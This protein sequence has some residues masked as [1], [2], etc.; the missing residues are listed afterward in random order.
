MFFKT[1]STGSTS[2][3]FWGSARYSDRL[4]DF[5]VTIPRFYKDVYVNSFFPCTARLSNS[6]PTECFCLTY[7]LGGFKSSINKRLFNRFP[8]SPNLFVLLFVVTPCMPHSG[9]T[10]L[11]GVNSS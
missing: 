1:G 4:H 5:S 8:V 6:L 11:H 7:D 2:F 10:A 3:F 9:F